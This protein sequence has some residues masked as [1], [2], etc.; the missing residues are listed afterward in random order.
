V[1]ADAIA[2]FAPEQ[3]DVVLTHLLSHGKPVLTDG[4][5]DD[6]DLVARM[7]G[8]GVTDVVSRPVRADQLTSKLERA[9]KK[10]ARKQG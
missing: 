6:L 8:L 2:I 3:G 4:A 9:V 7:V 1:P 5:A 10:A